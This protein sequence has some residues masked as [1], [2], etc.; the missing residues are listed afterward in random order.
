M[1]PLRF[2]LPATLLLLVSACGSASDS[3]GSE[4]SAATTSTSTS[5]TDGQSSAPDS[6]P[7]E[8]PAVDPHTAETTAIDSTEPVPATTQVVPSGDGELPFG[9]RPCAAEFSVI[10]TDPGFYRDE[11][12]YVGNEQP[13][14]Q[15]RAWAEQQPGYEDIWIDRENNGW[16]VVGF[17]SDVEQRQADLEAEFPGVGV[18]AAE[19][20]FGMA[21]LDQLRDD[22]F[23]TM[24]ANGMP[25]E[26][27]AS[28]PSGEVSVF[29]GVLDEATL[30][31]FAEFADDPVCFDGVDPVDAVI[32]GP[33]PTEGEGWRL[34]AVERTGESYRT[35]VATDETQYGSLWDLSGVT[36][37]R[38]PVDFETDIVVWFGA[39]YGSSC[40]IRMD[41][42]VFDL[43]RSIAHGD[44]VV[45]GNPSACNADANPEAYLVA[46]ERAALPVG[47]FSVQLSEQDPPNGVPE[48]RT[49][50]DADLSEPGS[51]AT[52]DQIGGDDALVE[53][54]D[55]GNVVSPGGIVEPGF[56]TVFGFDL[57]CPVDVVGPV[58]GVVWQSVDPERGQVVDQAWE[59]VAV[60]SNV[61]FTQILIE[62]DP[63]R[64][65]LTA[66][67]V[68]ENYT[69]AGSDIE[70][71][72]SS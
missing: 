13:T 17:S 20:T 11:P 37:E 15:V 3:T 53:Q 30:E 12:V 39:V 42:V 5:E 72:C 68:T 35:G 22:V 1:R 10:S 8:V 46:V 23:A 19:I 44:F 43:E 58:N 62:T 57:T 70:S 45:P 67:G 7:T 71:S 28:V 59:A 32:D 55:G 52:D 41:D 61:V 49:V 40:E 65:S 33:Q 9:L 31:P 63:V 18:V 64:M 27:G 47:P 16:V 34:L 25:I 54:A 26:G 21:E 56:A 4:G 14:D 69:P 60:Q 66:N 24:T 2:T 50:V 29:I 38:P 48:E 36:T 51:V 6:E